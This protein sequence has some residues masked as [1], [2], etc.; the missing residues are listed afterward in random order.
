MSTL[1]VTHVIKY[2]RFS[3]SL[4]GRAWER[5][6]TESTCIVPL[7]V[8]YQGQ[9]Y[10]GESCIVLESQPTCSLVATIPKRLS[11]VVHEFCTAGEERW[12]QGYGQVCAKP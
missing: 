9:P 2:T 10:G 11:L 7:P 4:A 12:K 1:D 3:P 8:L 6:Y 5:G